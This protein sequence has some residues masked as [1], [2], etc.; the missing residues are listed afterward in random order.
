MVKPLGSQKHQPQITESIHSTVKYDLVGKLTQETLLTRST[1]AG[2]LHNEAE[3][4]EQYK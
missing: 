1:I 3:V 2:I 4:F